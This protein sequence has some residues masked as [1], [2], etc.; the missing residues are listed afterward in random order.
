MRASLV[1]KN[2][3]ITEKISRQNP[4]GVYAFLVDNRAGKQEIAEAI[5]KTFSVKVK[6]V[7]ITR[8]A[9]KVK[10][11]GQ[12]RKFAKVGGGKKAVVKLA[13]GQTINL[14]SPKAE[15]Q[16]KKEKNEKETKK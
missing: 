9:S 2:A 8:I 1:I 13:K 12:T 3:I 14:L 10:R 4:E 16:A 6:R 11:I 5:S 7:N 15:K